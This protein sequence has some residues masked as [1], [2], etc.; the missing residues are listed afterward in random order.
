MHMKSTVDHIFSLER[1]SMKAVAICSLAEGSSRLSRQVRAKLSCDPSV[2]VEKTS[3]TSGPVGETR[4]Y[5]RIKLDIRKA[6]EHR[7]FLAIKMIQ[8]VIGK[9]PINRRRRQHPDQ[10]CL[11]QSDLLM[12]A[13][14]AGHGLEQAWP[15]RKVISL[16]NDV[17]ETKEKAESVA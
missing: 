2:V 14:L 17:G 13:I 7:E 11:G 16:A 6:A 12:H 1:R 3:G 8:V 4:M 10:A 9:K 15:V 5:S